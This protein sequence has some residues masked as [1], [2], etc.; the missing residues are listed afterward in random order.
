LDSRIGPLRGRA[1]VLHLDRERD[2]VAEPPG[3][4]RR[5][6]APAESRAEL[7]RAEEELARGAEALARQR[8]LARLGERRG[9][10]LR[11]LG[12]RFALELLVQPRRLVEMERADLQQLLAGALRQPCGEERVVLGARRLRQP[13]VGALADQDVLE[14]E[15]RL[16]A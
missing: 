14:L 7:D 15:R 4:A 9:S 1:D 11:E 10:L 12:R 3:R 16:V 5:G 6:E 13:A 2:V 8:A